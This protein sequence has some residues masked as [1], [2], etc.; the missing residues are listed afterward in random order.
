LESTLPTDQTNQPQVK[1]AEIIP[2]STSGTQ[3]GAD[4]HLIQIEIGN[5][6]ICDVTYPRNVRT[7]RGH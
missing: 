7:G 6:R 5:G 4:T 3:K 2:R 1:N